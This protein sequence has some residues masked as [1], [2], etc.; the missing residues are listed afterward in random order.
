MVMAA[1][2]SRSVWT[3][4]CLLAAL[5]AAGCGR[6]SD[7]TGAASPVVGSN[8]AVA[9]AVA[10]SAVA[11]ATDDAEV[12]ASA[13]VTNTSVAPSASVVAAASAATTSTAASARARP[14]PGEFQ[15]PVLKTDFADPGVLKDGD[16]YYA[17]ATNTVGRNVQVA[18]S[19][20][21]VE[22]DVL[23]DA[24][25]VLPDWTR[26]NFTWAPEVM[27]IGDKYAL[28]YT[29]RDKASNRQCVGVATS[30]KPQ[31]RFKDAL[32]KPLVCQVEEGG[33]IDASPF[34]DGEKLYLYYKNDGNCCAKPTY[35]Y[36]QELAADGLSLIGEPTRLVQNDTA[37]EGPLVEAP[38]MWKHDDTYYLFFSGNRYDTPAYAIGYATCESPM[39]PC[40][41]AQANPIVE[42]LLSKPPV[43]GPGH[44]T[45]ITDDDGETW[46]VY[47]AWEVSPAGLKT[48]RRFMWIDQV[49]WKD[50]KPVLQ[51]PTTEPQPVP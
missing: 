34:Q 28:Y 26:P 19:T 1:R 47:H 37:W 7:A 40:E 36:A 8:Q 16:T 41:D 49:V 21:L 22:W 20:D 4:V 48:N 44:Q 39:G 24:M 38:T 51:G 33:T 18:R 31:G 35:L 14:G 3:I 43:V 25:P 13:S 9:S 27:K 5:L 50:G 11:S 32:G 10:P 6:E 12:S 17:Y 2:S 30:D 29:A 15:N 42:S 46:L 23:T 45:I